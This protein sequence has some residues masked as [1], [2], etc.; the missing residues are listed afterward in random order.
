MRVL[1]ALANGNLYSN[2]TPYRFPDSIG[3]F[4]KQ[5]NLLA[6]EVLVTQRRDDESKAVVTFLYCS[7]ALRVLF[8]NR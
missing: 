6:T 1:C 3:S 8:L 7:E 5:A 2:V 4:F